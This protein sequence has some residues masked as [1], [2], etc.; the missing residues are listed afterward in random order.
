MFPLFSYFS[1]GIEISIGPGPTFTGY[2]IARQPQDL[3]VRPRQALAEALQAQRLE[4]LDAL[5]TVRA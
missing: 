4:D 3:P 1:S 5:P 2:A